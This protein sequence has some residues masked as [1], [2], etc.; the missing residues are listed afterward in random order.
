[1]DPCATQSRTAPP[2]TTAADRQTKKSRF[3][4]HLLSLPLTLS[5]KNLTNRGKRGNILENQFQK[6]P[7]SQ[8]ERVLKP[9]LLRRD[10]TSNRPGFKTIAETASGKPSGSTARV[11]SALNSPIA[12]PIIQMKS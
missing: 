2:T 5:T 12:H 6:H 10:T 11:S 4:T 1:V 3:I 8:R 9:L 7:L